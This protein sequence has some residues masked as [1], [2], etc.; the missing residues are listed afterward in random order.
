MC[1]CP[2]D[3]LSLWVI[4]K[5]IHD[6]SNS[7]SQLQGKRHTA[8]SQ[9]ISKTRTACLTFWH[10]SE[11]LKLK[12]S[13]YTGLGQDF[14]TEPVTTVTAGV[15][16]ISAETMVSTMKAVVCLFL[17]LSVCSVRGN[18]IPLE[19]NETIRDLLGHYVSI[20][21]L[22]L[23]VL[24]M[25][26]YCIYSVSICITDTDTTDTSSLFPPPV[27]LSFWRFHYK[28]TH[29]HTH[30]CLHTHTH[31]CTHTFFIHCM[32]SYF[33]Q[34][35]TNISLSYIQYIIQVVK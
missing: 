13:D 18:Y 27:S 33:S 19:M 5:C 30:T 22:L 1:L 21:I 17:C 35:C 8:V 3:S 7:L 6:K 28:Y 2:F 11:E 26:F 12:S 9:T 29:T 16:Q 14:V 23:L 4:N 25:L 15:L 34:M 31:A 24:L 20:M 32:S 10:H